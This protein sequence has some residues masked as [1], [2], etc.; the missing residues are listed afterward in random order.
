MTGRLRAGSALAL[1]IA[2]VYCTIRR[3]H[4]PRSRASEHARLLVEKTRVRD[5]PKVGPNMHEI[6]PEEL[7]QSTSASDP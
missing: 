2:V 6:S 7:P 3:L 1:G 5:L 4:P